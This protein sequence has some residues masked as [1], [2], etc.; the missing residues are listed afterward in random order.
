L[1]KGRALARPSERS[2]R[3]EPIVRRGGKTDIGFAGDAKCTSRRTE[4]AGNERGGVCRHN[5]AWRAKPSAPM[6]G[7]ECRPKRER[8][9]AILRAEPDRFQPVLQMVKDDFDTAMLCA[10]HIF[11]AS[12][13]I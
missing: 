2:E 3:F 13:H 6:K 9:S 12:L 8:K 10:E 1:V 5:Q 7:R 11:N 4:M